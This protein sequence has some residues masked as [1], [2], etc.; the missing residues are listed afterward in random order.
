[1]R[2]CWGVGILKAGTLGRR[3]CHL[4]GGRRVAPSQ[5]APNTPSG[6]ASILASEMA[7][8]RNRY[9]RRIRFRS[10]RCVSSEEADKSHGPAARVNL[11]LN[12]TE[13]C[14]AYP[15]FALAG[16]SHASDE[17]CHLATRRIEQSQKLST[18]LSTNGNGRIG[19]TR[20]VR[21]QS[22]KKR[23]EIPDESVW[24]STGWDGRVRFCKPLV[25]GSNPSAGTR[26]QCRL[27]SL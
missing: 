1:E 11:A 4:R 8:I 20:Y 16:A 14:D 27:S 22:S 24:E 2:A 23:P 12:A 10:Y 3:R 26:N 25:G 13:R 15:P 9:R 19:T 6:P 18:K 21:P 7:S 17:R 5:A